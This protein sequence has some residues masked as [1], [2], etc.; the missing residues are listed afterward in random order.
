MT[1]AKMNT[2][3]MILIEHPASKEKMPSPPFYS[4][5]DLGRTLRAI[6]IVAVIGFVSVLSS[7][8]FGANPAEELLSTAS[9][10][11]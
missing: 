11:A 5:R 1:P 8:A 2:S 7:S 4:N 6:A 10:A 9:Q 3:K